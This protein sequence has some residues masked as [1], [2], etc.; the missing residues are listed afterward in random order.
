MTVL[1]AAAVVTFGIVGSG[2]ATSIVVLATLAVFATTMLVTYLFRRYLDRRPWHDIGIARPGR[3][4]LIGL[5]AG[6]VVGVAAIAVWFGIE[7]AAGWAEVTG[8]SVTA[9]GA[10]S[11]ALTVV[12]GV[13]LVL[14]S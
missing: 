14:R 5:A 6:F 7:V 9:R 3:G 8:W 13:V 10:S 2:A 11:A 1:A 12:V 4:E